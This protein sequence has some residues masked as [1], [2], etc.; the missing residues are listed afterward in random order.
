MINIYTDGSSRGNPG[1]GGYGTVLTFNQHRKEISEGFRLTT[2]NRMELLAAIIGLE[3]LKEPGREV[4][5][6]SDSKYV[7]DSVEKGWIWDW[8]KKNFKDKKNEDLW[9]RFIYIYKK[10]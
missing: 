8:E 7:V 2:N 9:R 5:I 10:H 3:S 6:H 1:P 4:T